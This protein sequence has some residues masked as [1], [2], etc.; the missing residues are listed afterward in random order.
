MFTSDEKRAL[1]KK[2]NIVYDLKPRQLIN[3]MWWELFNKKK[4]KEFYNSLNIGKAAIFAYKDA[5]NLK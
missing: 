4:I 3:L 5:K 1:L 2:V